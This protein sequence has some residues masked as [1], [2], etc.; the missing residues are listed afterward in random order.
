VSVYR[1]AA[2]VVDPK[3]TRLERFMAFWCRHGW[4]PLDVYD[5]GFESLDEELDRMPSWRCRY[6]G[7]EVQRSY[8]WP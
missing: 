2:V 5:P 6:C 7:A 3:P 8:M 1:Q 4:H